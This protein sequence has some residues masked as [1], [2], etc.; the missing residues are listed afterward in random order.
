MSTYSVRTPHTR[1]N[2]TV[3][4]STYWTYQVQYYKYKLKVQYPYVRVRTTSTTTVENK[5]SAVWKAGS[6]H[7]WIEVQKQQAKQ[8]RREAR[9]LLL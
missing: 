7:D 1:R 2:A 4:A 8:A 5:I 3:Y 6:W 9:S